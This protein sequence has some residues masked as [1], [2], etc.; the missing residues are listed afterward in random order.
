MRNPIPSFFI[1]HPS[2]TLGRRPSFFIFHCSLIIA[3]SFIITSCT[4]ATVPKTAKLTGR[5]VLVNDTGDTAFDP[6]DF[7]GAIVSIFNIADI[8]TTILRINQEYPHIGVQINQETEFDHRLQTPLSIVASDVDGNYVFEE[9]SPGTYNLVARKDEWGTATVFRLHLAGDTEFPDILLYPQRI[10]PNYW[11]SEFTCYAGRE[12]YSDI[13]I[14][15]GQASNLTMETGTKIV[16]GSGA[17]LSIY[18]NV[19]VDKSN[20]SSFVSFDSISNE[21]FNGLI[22]NNNTHDYD[23]SNILIRNSDNG[24]RISV[25]ALTLEDSYFKTRYHSV[26]VLYAGSISIENC[27]FIGNESDHQIQNSGLYV[28]NSNIG[29]TR[30]VFVNNIMGFECRTFCKGVV[31]DCYFANNGTAIQAVFDCDLQVSYS[32]FMRN[33]IGVSNASR[34]KA[35]IN[36]CDFADKIG[37]YNYTYQGFTSDGGDTFFVARNNNLLCTEYAVKSKAV[38][39]V[40][41]GEHVISTATNN[42]WGTSNPSHVDALIWDSHDEDPNMY[43][44]EHYTSLVEYLPI[45]NNRVAGAGVR[46]N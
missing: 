2:L 30:S 32:T 3:V 17:S 18:G 37:I 11:D 34:S 1:V 40:I 9:I 31:T 7:S 8:D 41:T 20:G 44:Y 24:L 29:L 42:Y 14:I 36:Y 16:L 13:D 19:S 25:N 27:L 4:K 21:P 38:S 33:Q 26:N 5:I 46:T 28:F 22:I 45:H 35:S 12:Y 6:I 23:L 39:Y 10:L 43:L 15:F